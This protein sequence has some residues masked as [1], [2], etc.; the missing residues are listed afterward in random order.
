MRKGL[1]GLAALMFAPALDAQTL[2]VPTMFPT[3]QDALDAA[4]S[5]AVVVVHG[6]TWGPITITRP[7]TLI[8]DPTPII[9]GLDGF[10]SPIT[11][12]G[13][14][15]GQVTL[16]SIHAG[17]SF[18]DSIVS[19]VPPPGIQG[20]GFDELYIADSGIVAPTRGQFGCT[21]LG[22]GNSAIDVDVPLLVLERSFAIGGGACID[23][24]CTGAPP[25]WIP[26]PAIVAGTVVMLD[27]GAQGGSNGSFQNVNWPTDAECDPANCPF[28][29]GGTGV[30][31]GTLYFNGSVPLAFGGQGARWSP[32]SGSFC[33]Q[34]PNGQDVIASQV[35]ALPDVIAIGNTVGRRITLILSAP[36][37]LARL[38]V[39]DDLVSPSLVPGFGY[40]FL[41]PGTTRSLGAV[42]TPG[43]VAF[44]L[45]RVLSL[46]GRTIAFQ[47][48]DPTVGLSEPVSVAFFPQPTSDAPRRR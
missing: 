1:C 19:A 2:H 46:I 9:G 48:M 40:S 6:G 12:A 35:V 17:D 11:L 28:L 42:A 29:P 36:G 14:G 44:D 34:S 8:G 32:C 23:D 16:S 5:G 26:P 7:V 43:T 15:T 30:S 39:A 3:V 27:S 45:P 33:C 37:P 18:P 38:L 20:G 24:A 41:D 10:S 25:D 22:L 47:L 21:G 13:S 4:P 31:C